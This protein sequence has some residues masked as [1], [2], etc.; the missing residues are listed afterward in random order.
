MKNSL[1]TEKGLKRLYANAERTL[2][3]QVL[4]PLEKRDEGLIEECEQTMLYCRE[5]LDRMSRAEAER[6]A[7]PAFRR[8]RSWVAA[9][10]A[11]AVL[12]VAAT[13]VY[14]AGVTVLSRRA[15]VDGKSVRI[16]YSGEGSALPEASAGVNGAPE[17]Y[18]PAGSNEGLLTPTHVSSEEELKSLLPEGMLY[19]GEELEFVGAELYGSDDAVEVIRAEYSLSGS[20]IIIEFDPTEDDVP[21]YWARS[22]FVSDNYTLVYDRELEGVACFMAKADGHSICDFKY[23][24]ACYTVG[25]SVEPEVLEEI[26]INMLK[27][28]DRNE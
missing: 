27:E 24:P 23:G 13:A 1:T 6:A 2:D 11:L 9:L 17:Y 22:F 18:Y 15:Y 7:Q 14:A 28:A 26:V 16:D 4:M 19:P 12:V 25:G 5:E 8:R 3:R 20:R 10:S 21:G